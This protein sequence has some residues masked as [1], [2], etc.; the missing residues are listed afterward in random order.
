MITPAISICVPAYNAAAWIEQTL[1]SV[2]CQTRGDFELLVLDDCSVDDTLSL[3]RRYQDSRIRVLT[4]E[5]N[6][7][8]EASWNRLLAEARGEFVK[9]LCCDDLLYPEC[10]AVQARVLEDPARRSV[11]IVCG[12]RDI[13][14]DAGRV[15][16][17]RRGLR[18]MAAAAG[19]EI[20]RR[21]VTSGRNLLGEPLTV[22]FR[23]DLL[24]T[25]GGFDAIQP[26]CIDMDMWCRLLAVTD[27]AV[28]PETVGA[29]RVS[30]SS[31]SFRLAGRQA[32]QDRAFFSRVRSQIVPE[33][34]AWQLRLGQ[35][36][37]TR[38]AF[39]RQLLYAWLRRPGRMPCS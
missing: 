26:Y 15:L 29:F 32:S 35:F 3:V 10:L 24:Q 7:G 22:L 37:C 30:L 20:V 34:P 4:N 25:V 1:D 9:L 33:V 5:S 16:V 18:P 8:A 27:L 39:L 21:I 2:L 14:D 12:P 23:R 31:W 6:R 13:I 28:V 17:R 19:R 11:G 38:D 36:R